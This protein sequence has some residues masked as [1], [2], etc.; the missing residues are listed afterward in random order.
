MGAHEAVR[1][2]LELELMALLDRITTDPN[3]MGGKPCIR[4]M[5]VTVGMVV[6]MIASG[7][8]A[9]DLLRLYPYSERQAA[10]DSAAKPSVRIVI[11]MNLSPEW[12]GAFQTVNVDAVHW[13]AVGSPKADDSEILDYARAAGAVLLTHDLDFPRLLASARAN[14]PSVILLRAQNVD[15]SQWLATITD[16]LRDHAA[17]LSAGAIVSVDETRS[18]VRIL[19]LH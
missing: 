1:Q 8:S 15:P 13:S 9:D 7:H 14:G 19:P 10:Y 3:V 2:R 4:G 17:A 6:G 18:R 16:V 5:R 12:V 11:D